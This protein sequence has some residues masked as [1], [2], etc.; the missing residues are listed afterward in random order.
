[1]NAGQAGVLLQGGKDHPERAQ[2]DPAPPLPPPPLQQEA[3][4]KLGFSAKKDHDESPRKLYEGVDIGEGT[5]G[6][7]TYMRTDSVV[8]SSQ[9]LTGR[10]R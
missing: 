1:M 3:A 8:L 9:A 5:A 2:K 6:L 10:G 7:I 4:R